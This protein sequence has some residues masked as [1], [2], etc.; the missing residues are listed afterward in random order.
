MPTPKTSGLQN[1]YR[2]EGQ[3]SGKQVTPQTKGQGS[4]KKK[5]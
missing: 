1:I 5:K 4:K 3:K 2:A